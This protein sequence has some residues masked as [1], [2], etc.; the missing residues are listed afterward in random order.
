MTCLC[1]DQKV[2]PDTERSILGSWPAEGHAHVV[3]GDLLTVAGP[4]APPIHHSIP[5]CR[6]EASEAGC[7]GGLGAVAYPW[8]HRLH[9]ECCGS[10]VTTWSSST[11]APV[12]CAQT[13]RL[14]N[15]FSPAVAAK[16]LTVRR[17]QSANAA[18]NWGRDGEGQETEII[19]LT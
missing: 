1:V 5:R 3:V 9:Q 11:T 2:S 8:H 13:C 4:T 19:R 12:S 14:S 16:A 15:T 10:S 18:I 7:P 17:T 6:G